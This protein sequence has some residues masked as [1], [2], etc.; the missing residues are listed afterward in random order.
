MLS[1]KSHQRRAGVKLRND[2]GSPFFNAA[3]A[4]RGELFRLKEKEVADLDE[5]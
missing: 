4:L 2:N 3:E 5:I 1:D